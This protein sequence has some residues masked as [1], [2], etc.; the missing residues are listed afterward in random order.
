MKIAFLT[1]L[2]FVSLVRIKHVTFI[3]C[4]ISMWCKGAVSLFNRVLQCQVKTLRRNV[5]HLNPLIR[6]FPLHN[7]S[8]GIDIGTTGIIRNSVQFAH[9][10]VLPDT[11]VPKNSYQTAFY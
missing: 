4:N 2:K 10:L 11:S 1:H 7:N 5:T 9:V 3:D 8:L 6:I